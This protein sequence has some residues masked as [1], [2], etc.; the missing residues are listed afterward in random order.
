MPLKEII[1]FDCENYRKHINTVSGNTGIL[2]NIV[3]AV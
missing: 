3:V 1:S 2:F